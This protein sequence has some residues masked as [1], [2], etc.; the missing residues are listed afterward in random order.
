MRTHDARAQ[1]SSRAFFGALLGGKA[2]SPSF[3]ALPPFFSSFFL[4][5]LLY[6]RVDDKTSTSW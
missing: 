5:L 3:C 4:F 6:R 1:L 2:F